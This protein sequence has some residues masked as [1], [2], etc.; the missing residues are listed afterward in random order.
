MLMEFLT[1]K[2]PAKSGIKKLNGC[3]WNVYNYTTMLSR[4]LRV[5]N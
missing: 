5:R 2:C 3:I 1:K 4:V